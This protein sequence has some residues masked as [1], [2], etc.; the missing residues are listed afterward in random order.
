[1]IS[2]RQAMALG[3]YRAPDGRLHADFRHFDPVL[4]LGWQR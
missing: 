3:F 2:P 4:F 1:M